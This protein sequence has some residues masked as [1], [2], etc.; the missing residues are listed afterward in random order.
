M[1]P[2]K[3]DSQNPHASAEVR[4]RHAK[5]AADATQKGRK[6]ASIV[7]L[8]VILVVLVLGVIAG[9]AFMLQQ[10]AQLERAAQEAAEAPIPTTPESSETSEEQQLVENPI[11]F[12]SLQAENTDIYAWLY[13]PDTNINYP[14]MQHAE[15]DSYY[16]HTNRYHEFSLEGAI[17]SQSMNSKDFSDPVTVLYGHNNA[18]GAMFATLH[19]FEDASFFQSHDTFYIYTPGHILT[20]HI[21]SAYEYDDR[22]ILN[23]FDFSDTATVKEYFSG[24]LNPSTS[25]VR[26]VREGSELT[27]S[28]TIVQLSTCMS[29]P[30]K[31]NSRYL[32]SGVLVDD[33]PTY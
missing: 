4:G 32:V 10:N 17:F 5:P 28:D 9:V 30:S 29:E 19:N 14:V 27:T 15:D 20:Y 23:S 6:K 7:A 25:L 21:V 33:Q 8:S 18:N 13:V 2:A 26:N 11:D 31:A 12:A 22:H 16:L 1:S 3:N 24:V